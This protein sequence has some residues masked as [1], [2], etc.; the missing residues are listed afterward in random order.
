MAYVSITGLRVKSLWA[1]PLFWRHAIP[2]M[3]QARRAPGIVMAEARKID[4]VQH[5]LTV[6]RSRDH[7]RAYLTSGAHM[8]AMKSFRR[9][10]T[11]ATC[12]YEAEGAP[13]WDEA[14]AYWR[15]H[16]RPY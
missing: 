4:G 15:E 11:G 7:M 2:A 1:A 16:A 13:T 10:A 14:V 9:I 3:A 8:A 12:G 6:W 5:T